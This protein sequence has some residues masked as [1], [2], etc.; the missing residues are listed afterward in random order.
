MAQ[1]QVHDLLRDGER[2]DAV[3][4]ELYG[5]VGLEVEVVLEALDGLGAA[6]ALHVLG[7]VQELA[8]LG[9]A[10]AEVAARYLQV[11]HFATHLE[12]LEYVPSRR[13]VEFLLLSFDIF[14]FF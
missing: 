6:V 5:E 8:A 7:V 1:Q 2:R 12:T 14:M 3:L 11:L 4:A 10:L 13:E 9:L